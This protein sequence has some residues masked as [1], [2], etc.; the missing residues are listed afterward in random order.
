MGSLRS[1]IRPI[2][3]DIFLLKNEKGEL[4][5]CADWR[6][7][8]KEDRYYALDWIRERATL[9]IEVSYSMIKDIPA[10]Y[11]NGVLLLWFSDRCEWIA[12]SYV[13][14]LRGTKG[15]RTVRNL[16][17]LNEKGEKIIGKS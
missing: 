1:L 4:W 3:F 17:K 15:E 14:E 12:V 13:R 7:V 6:T 9:G 11:N 5:L 10:D 8:P 16:R 2:L